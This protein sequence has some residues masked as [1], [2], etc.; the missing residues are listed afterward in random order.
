MGEFHARSGLATRGGRGA[1]GVVLMLVRGGG[2]GGVSFCSK[3]KRKSNW[4][5][6]PS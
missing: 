1:E 3:R 6:G 2:G 4:E 5:L